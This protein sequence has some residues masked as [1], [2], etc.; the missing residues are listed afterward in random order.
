MHMYGNLAY[1]R[2]SETLWLGRFRGGKG[3]EVHKIS[4]LG[5]GYVL[6]GLQRVIEE[7]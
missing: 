1:R 3:M 2:E 6:Q 7:C 5:M 4:E